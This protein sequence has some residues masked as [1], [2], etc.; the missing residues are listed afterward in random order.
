VSPLE[1]DEKLAAALGRMTGTWSHLEC[2]LTLIFQKATGMDGNVAACIFDSFRNT[3]TQRNVLL[4][5]VAISNRLNDWE[6]A[7]L[8]DALKSY[9]ALA[10]KRNA[11]AHNPFGWTNVNDPKSLYIMQ[12]QHGWKS[13]DGI[14]YTA[15]PIT[16]E[17][18]QALTKEIDFLRLRMLAIAMPNHFTLPPELRQP[19]QS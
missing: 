14:P 6:T 7:L 10:D 16:T 11:L 8:K 13:E 4:R 17:E 15:C 3:H 9:I 1:A 18:I 19:E 2:L 5:V 12:K